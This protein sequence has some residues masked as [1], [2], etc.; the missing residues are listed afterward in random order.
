[1][2][3]A[4]QHLALGEG[5]LTP[6]PP[7][8]M[9]TWDYIGRKPCGCYVAVIPFALEPFD[10]ASRLAKWNKAGIIPERC[11][12]GQAKRFLRKCKCTLANQD[13]LL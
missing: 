1:M 6:A 8:H 10:I 9:K 7:N 3:W 13:A 5:K 4:G 12:V 11:E 2:V